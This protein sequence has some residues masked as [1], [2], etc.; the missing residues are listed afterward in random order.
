[1]KSEIISIDGENIKFF[2]GGNA[3]ENFEIIDL[4]KPDDLWFHVDDL[5]S[6]HVIASISD[7]IDNKSKK[8]IRYIVKQGALLCKKYSKYKSVSELPI[9]YT[10][11]SN[12]H[13]T[14]IIGSVI[15]TNSK[16][17]KI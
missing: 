17:I 7:I 3:K 16:I 14:D 9:T 10:Y 5:P 4:A 15:T 12:V 13:K 6:C 2:I 8:D 1:M 11:I